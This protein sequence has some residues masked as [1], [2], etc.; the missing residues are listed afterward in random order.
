MLA[1][2]V[3]ALLGVAL[4]AG[5]GVVVDG[6]GSDQG[7]HPAPVT[8][9]GPALYGDVAQRLGDEG[10]AHPVFSAAAARSGWSTR[11]PRPSSSPG[12]A[13]ARRCPARE[14]C[15]SRRARSTPT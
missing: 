14:R 6:A 8:T 5:C 12:W 1:R 11:A 2:P 15:T 4:L 7:V 10:T 3:C 9:P 13:A